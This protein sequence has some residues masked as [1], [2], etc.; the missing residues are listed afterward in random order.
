MGP[1]D[2]EGLS[3]SVG[4][5]KIFPSY[6]HREPSGPMRETQPQENDTRDE[7]QAVSSDLKGESDPKGEPAPVEFSV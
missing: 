3:V 7:P 1:P 2:R 4:T 5:I 6:Q